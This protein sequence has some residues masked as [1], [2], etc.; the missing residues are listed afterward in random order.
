[1]ALLSPTELGSLINS[2]WS[3]ERTLSANL[4]TV[5]Y[6]ALELALSRLPAP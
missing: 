4:Y 5:I 2:T 3:S 1:M 6:A